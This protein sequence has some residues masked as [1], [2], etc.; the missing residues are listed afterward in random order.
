MTCPC[1]Q[2]LTDQQKT[3]FNQQMGKN[4]IQNLN[5]A[6]AGTV[7]GDLGNALTKANGIAN[8]I[9]VTTGANLS[10]A[11]A[12]RAA[13]VDV[14][15]LNNLTSKITGMQSKVTSFK[16]QADKMS[17]P[18]YLISV[19]GSMSFYAN[20]GCALGIEGL[21]IGVSVDVITGK[22]GSTI[23]VAGNVSADL[24]SLL[25]NFN[26]TAAGTSIQ[27]AA[28][29]FS[30]GLEGITTKIN[31]A[32]SALDKVTTDCTKMID[33]GLGKVTEF[34]QVNFFTNLLKDA[35]D[36]CNVLS[37]KI[38]D[39]GLMTPDFQSMAQSAIAST[40]GGTSR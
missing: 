15:K 21:D 36:P 6:K 38:K 5:G 32:T 28:N 14:S 11:E 20:L 10:K 33:Q 17:D 24:T 8:L 37:A 39:S 13:G 30:Q 26:N 19:V 34:S 9:G 4:F 35:S 31:D 2:K 27:D 18:G 16:N 40:S 25:D 1:K 7:A 3:L 23:N 12:L 22:G 29:K